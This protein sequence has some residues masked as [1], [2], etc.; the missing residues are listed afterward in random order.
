LSGSL[1]VFKLR[2]GAKRGSVRKTKRDKLKSNSCPHG[3]EKKQ[4]RECGGLPTIARILFLSARTR[5]RK[6]N[7]PFEIT[8]E[9]ILELIGEGTCPVF[10]T[11]YNLT[12]DRERT[13]TSASLDKFNPKLGYV[14]GNVAVI[15]WR[16]NNLKHDATTNEMLRLWV[17]MKQ[18]ELGTQ[19]IGTYIGPTV[20]TSNIEWN[21]RLAEKNGVD[22]NRY[23]GVK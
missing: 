15:S 8:Q 1:F 14:R 18:R 19:A 9:D 4:C 13:D 6:S 2:F 16:A 20:S 17:W 23:L 11:P 22:A 10:G 5:A 3:R 7:L 21:R 12:N